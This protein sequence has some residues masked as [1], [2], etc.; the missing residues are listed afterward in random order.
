MDPQAA[1]AA[2][3]EAVVADKWGDASEA[4]DNLLE[5]LTRGGFP[6]T[7]TGHRVFDAMVAQATCR[8]VSEWDV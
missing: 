5:W 8:R 7:I 2:M 3:I 6:P 1:W 4:A